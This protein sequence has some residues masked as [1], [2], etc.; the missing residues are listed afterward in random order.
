MS[1]P[2]RVDR[3]RNPD[4]GYTDNDEVN[5]SRGEIPCFTGENAMKNSKLDM[6]GAIVLG[7]V[8][9]CMLAGWPFY[10]L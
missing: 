2:A 3:R 7:I 10:P 8:L 9:G 6:L 5:H 1:V 4:A